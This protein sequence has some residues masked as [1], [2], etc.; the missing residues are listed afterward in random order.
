MHQSTQISEH[1]KFS[2]TSL[3]NES[4]KHS[5]A[6]LI[7]LLRPNIKE[8]NEEIGQE[9]KDTIDEGEKIIRKEKKNTFEKENSDKPG[10][11]Q[12]LSPEFCKAGS[13]GDK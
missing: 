11:V 12:L 5:G 10:Q 13:E 3:H 7:L 9:K 2:G 6:K 4:Y 1:R 8:S